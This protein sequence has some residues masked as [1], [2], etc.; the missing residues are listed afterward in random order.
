MFGSGFD[1]TANRLFGPQPRAAAYCCMW[2]IHVGDLKG[3]ISISD[4]QILMAAMTAFRLNFTDK[5]NAPAK[6]YSPP[7][8]SDGQFIQRF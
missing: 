6:E 4:T 7:L 2:E 8:D 5:P 1:I 3:T